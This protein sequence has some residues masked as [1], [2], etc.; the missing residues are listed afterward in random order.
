MRNHMAAGWFYSPSQIVRHFSTR[1]SSLSP[2]KNMLRNP[3]AILQELTSHQ[4]LMFAAGF[5]GWTWDSFDFFTVSMTIIEISEAF[6]V[7]YSDVSW[8]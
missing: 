5:L 8:V 3:V 1:L 4:W 7:S 2:P 6:D